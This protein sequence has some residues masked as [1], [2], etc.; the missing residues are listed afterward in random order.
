MATWHPVYALQSTT[1]MTKDGGRYPVDIGEIRR[2]DDPVVLAQPWVFTTDVTQVMVRTPGWNPGD[3][4]DAPVEQA[5][6][7]PGEKRASVRRG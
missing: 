2:S 7:A 1:V 6:A 3:L 5:T 4:D